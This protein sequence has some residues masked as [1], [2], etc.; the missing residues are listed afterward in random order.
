MNTTIAAKNGFRCLQVKQTNHNCCQIRGAPNFA[1][2][3]FY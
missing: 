2:T 3:K 1:A